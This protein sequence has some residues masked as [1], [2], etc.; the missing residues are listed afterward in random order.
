[1]NQ[2]LEALLTSKVPLQ[3]KSCLRWTAGNE[4]PGAWCE[5]CTVTRF[6]WSMARPMKKQICGGSSVWSMRLEASLMH[7]DSWL[8]AMYI[9]MY[10]YIYSIYTWLLIHVFIVIIYIYTVS[11]VPEP[12][13][14]EKIIITN[15]HFLKGPLFKKKHSYSIWAG[16]NM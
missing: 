3:G 16:P 8:I 15:H 14:W 2:R 11:G 5:K 13:N 7:V 10:I 9:P 12:C 6:T 1:M 4:R